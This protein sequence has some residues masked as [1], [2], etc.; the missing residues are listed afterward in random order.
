LPRTARGSLCHAILELR[1]Y[2]FPIVRAKRLWTAAARTARREGR[3]ARANLR[4]RAAEEKQ[5]QK[6][7]SLKRA[8]ELER[9]PEEERKRTRERAGPEQ[10]L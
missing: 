4:Q 9:E 5:I 10:E 7:L 6:D 2:S 3:A 1:T 8:K